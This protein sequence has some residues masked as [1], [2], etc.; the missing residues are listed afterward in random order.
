MQETMPTK[1]RESTP[2]TGRQENI[3]TKLA[4]SAGKSTANKVKVRTH[5]D[6][7]TEHTSEHDKQPAASAAAGAAAT[8][9]SGT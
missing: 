8:A 2:V 3:P 6:S 7:G 4:G 1:T 9:G 5:N